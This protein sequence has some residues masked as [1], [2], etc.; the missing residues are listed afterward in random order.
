MN[1]TVLLGFILSVLFSPVA[2]G[3][4]LGLDPSAATVM[5]GDQLSLKVIVGDLGDTLLGDF[6]TAVVF[7]ATLLT[8]T[9]VTPSGV[10]GDAAAGYGVEVRFDW[11]SL[12][13]GY[14]AFYLDTVLP[15]AVL[16]SLQS[17]SPLVLATLSFTVG[18]LTSC[19]TEVRLSTWRLDDYPDSTPIPVTTLQSAVIRGSDVEVVPEPGTMIT[20]SVGLVYLALRRTA[21]RRRRERSSRYSSHAD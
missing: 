4:T 9:S 20:A 21:A 17:A 18:S 15:V 2:H 10:L 1:R 6:E 12:G 3:A 13:D 16:Q 11:F 8:L 19:C 14:E 5:P 7:D